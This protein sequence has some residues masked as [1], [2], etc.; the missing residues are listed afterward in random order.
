MARSRLLLTVSS[1]GAASRSR[2]W[3]SPSA[4]V[5]PSPLSAFGRLTP[6]TG[7]WVTAFL[8]Q[9]YSNSEDSAASRCRIVLP[10]SPRR[11][12]VVAPGD[13]M[14]AGHGAEFLRPGD[15]GEAHE[16]PRSRSRRRAVCCGLLRLA[17]HSISGGTSASRWNSAAVSNRSVG[18]IPL[19]I[20]NN[21][22]APLKAI[23]IHR[24]CLVPI[25]AYIFGDKSP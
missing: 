18:I 3:W 15:A 14:R 22:P 1:V 10:P 9:R 7:L 5:L 4:G 13:D 11:C 21:A 25:K 12:Q 6:L 19:V 17:N 24:L 8:S 2:A 16:I 20:K 23:D